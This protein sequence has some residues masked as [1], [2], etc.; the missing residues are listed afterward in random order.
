[1]AVSE[2]RNAVFVVLLTR[3]ASAVV[4]GAVASKLAEVK[5]SDTLGTEPVTTRSGKSPRVPAIFPS[6]SA[7]LAAEVKVIVV[8]NVAATPALTSASEGQSLPVVELVVTWMLPTGMA[9]SFCN[10]SRRVALAVGE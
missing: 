3:L 8:V 10:A 2:I 7:N 9:A 4:C 5:E 6:P 1:L